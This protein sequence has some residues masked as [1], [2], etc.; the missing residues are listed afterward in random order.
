M[1]RITTNKIAAV[2]NVDATLLLSVTK[3]F[4]LFLRKC[5]HI[6]DA[7][8]ITSIAAMM[9][10]IEGVGIIKSV[11]INYLSLFLLLGINRIAAAITAIT[12]TIMIIDNHDPG[13]NDGALCILTL[14]IFTAGH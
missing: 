11:G 4:P 13:M 8:E 7:M 1:N 6:A 10:T 3:N 12:T 5:S 2:I 9:N 14:L